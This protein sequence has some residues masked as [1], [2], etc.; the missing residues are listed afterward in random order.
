MN[1]PSLS[2]AQMS[3]FDFYVLLDRSGS[4]AEPRSKTIPTPRWDFAKELI[5]GICKQLVGIDDD[6]ITLVFF[7]SS[8]AVITGVSTP[9]K[10]SEVF[11]SYSPSGGT[12]LAPAIQA[13]EALRRNS[14]KKAFYLVV[15][16]GEPS[17]KVSIPGLIR[18]IANSLTADDQLS[19]Q[20][21]QTGDD[22]AATEFLKSLD[23]D[24]QT[25]FKAKF[26]IVNT[27]TDVEAEGYTLGELMYEAQN[28]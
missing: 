1:R 26:D 10:V 25:K 7:N 21:I 16:D 6:G 13:A 2:T 22:R 12:Q 19:I 8:P 3:E 23:D 9:E 20:F 5:T 28:D 27:M 17:D 15:T 14:G 11:S 24:L 18:D 4:M